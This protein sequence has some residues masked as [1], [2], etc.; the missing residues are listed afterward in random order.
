[1]VVVGSESLHPCRMECMSVGIMDSQSIYNTACNVTFSEFLNSNLA[2]VG[3]VG[4]AF[5]VFEASREERKEGGAG[6]GG[7]GGWN[8]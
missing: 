6:G 5:G 4:I 3:G 8:G 1:M 2:I 7:G